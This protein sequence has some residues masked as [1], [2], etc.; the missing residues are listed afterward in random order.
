ML[1]S[2][3]LPIS[4]CL[5]AVAAFWVGEVRGDWEDLLKSNAPVEKKAPERK[6]SW[7]DGLQIDT[8]SKI[9]SAADTQWQDLLLNDAKKQQS[10]QSESKE[11]RGLIDQMASADAATSISSQEKPLLISE[12]GLIFARLGDF[13]RAQQCCLRGYKM[14]E[15]MC[16]IDS[17]ESLLCMKNLAELF[18]SMGDDE[19]AEMILKEAVDICK[20][21][22]KKFE[23]LTPMF[24][25]RLSETQLQR[26]LY[27]KA[28][29]NS[30]LAVEACQKASMKEGLAYALAMESRALYF[31]SLGDVAK[32]E[33]FFHSELKALSGVKP[34][35]PV[36]DTC[37]SLLPST[38]TAA[39]L[40]LYEI[41]IA[42]NKLK[43]ASDI[44]PQVQKALKNSYGVFT[45]EEARFLKL[46]AVLAKQNGDLAGGNKSAQEYLRYVS[47]TLQGALAMVESQ[48]LGWQRTYLDYSLPVVFCSP[49]E[50]ADLVIK[51]K[52]VVLDSLIGDRVNLGKNNTESAILINK[53]LTAC[54][55]KLLQMQMSSSPDQAVLQESKNRIFYLERKLS[56]ESRYFYNAKISESNLEKVQET[57]NDG[58]ALVEFISYRAFPNIHFGEDQLGALVI[59]HKNPITWIPLGG[60]DKIK[61]QCDAVQALIGR[62]NASNQLKSQ[63]QSLYVA[64]W[65]GIVKSL[66]ANITNVYISPEG[67]LNFVPFPCLIDGGG[68]FAIEK[69]AM[70]YVGS[71]RDLLVKTA[72]QKSQ[73]ICIFANPKFELPAPPQSTSHSEKRHAAQDEFNKVTLTPLP[74][75]EREA[76][77]LSKV[78]DSCKW[79]PKLLLGT[80]ANKLAL[81][82]LRSPGILHLATHGFYLGGTSFSEVGSVQRG[83]SVKGIAPQNQEIKDKPVMN[84]M[85]QSGI[86]LTGAQNTFSLWNQ[87]SAPDPTNDGVLT[88]QDV[89]GLDLKGTWLVTLS[90][91]E[92]GLG[93]AKSG[94]G[95]F[96]LRR[97]FMMAGAQNLVMTL[98]PVSDDVTP[99]VMDDFYKEAMISQNAPA[100]LSKVQK[101]WLVKLRNE[102]GLQDAV[103]DIGPFSMVVMANPS[104]K[105]SEVI[106]TD[107][108]IKEKKDLER[109]EHQKQV[110]KSQDIDQLDK[111]FK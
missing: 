88:A 47:Q 37:A 83:M 1:I 70:S 14:A 33:E 63:L 95:V 40:N 77:S 16:G 5:A 78:A 98:W 48:R 9:Q 44:E 72:A 87:G 7:A 15:Q 23:S 2:P 21:N 66:P 97:A 41:L 69:H 80:E 20:A 19:R 35:P 31:R 13:T 94:E 58:D 50:L 60:G 92:T 3:N 81:T 111:L 85:V 67:F 51:W 91:C 110:P 102:K 24:L 38:S 79:R 55:Q 32:S 34:D 61:S 89:A 86:A 4:F 62:A 39:L 93:E 107:S 82:N 65:D 6:H 22:S 101:E 106:Q 57:L 36:K 8:F 43:E 96:G 105:S 73:E 76:L 42:Q 27:K 54:R 84:P 68:Q 56:E 25:A 53:E 64:L 99:L 10:V 109:K 100:S 90:A 28:E 17:R 18:M 29:S 26:G 108:E 45:L 52:G 75:T 46:H 59:T 49:N 11:I 12:F 103:R 74:G 30:A 71:G 104:S